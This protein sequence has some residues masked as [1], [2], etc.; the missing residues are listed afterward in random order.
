MH[1]SLKQLNEHS[2]TLHLIEQNENVYV[3]VSSV[4][5]IDTPYIMKRKALKSECVFFKASKLCILVKSKIKER[6]THTFLFTLKRRTNFLH[7]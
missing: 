3:R 1:D 2:F 7:F 5:L 6:K 4:F